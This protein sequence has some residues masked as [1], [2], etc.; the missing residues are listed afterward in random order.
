VKLGLRARVALTFGVLSLAV[1]IAVSGTTY[2]LARV[3]L[4]NQRETAALTRALLDARA[5]SASLDAG[6]PP[7]RVL[8]QIPSVGTSQPLLL[9]DG[10]WYTTGVTVSPES[11]PS[12]LIEVTSATGGAWQRFAVGSGPYLAVAVGLP[13]GLYVEVFPL[14][15]LDTTFVIAGWVV[16]VLA[17]G[18]FGVGATVGRGA[19]ARILRPLREL[20][21]G[22]RQVAAGDYSVRLQVTG[23][24]D[25]E[26]IS[27]SFNEMAE[28]VQSQISRERRF[29]ANVS[30]EL[31]SPLTS[32]LGTAELLERR[33]EAL[34][35]RDAHIV[36]V[37]VRQ[38]RR[39]SQMVLDL[40]E[41]SS[42]TADA[43][44][45]GET[46]DVTALVREVLRDRDLS[47]DL[48]HGPEALAHTDAR[49]FERIIGNLV[50]NAQ[51][52]GGGVT[53]IEVS[54][55]SEEGPVLITVDDEGPG[56]EPE[57][58]SRLFEPFTRGSGSAGTD[59]AGLGL[60]LVREQSRRLG[61]AVEI[62]A[63]PIGRGARFI[64]RLPREAPGVGVAP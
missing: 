64:V 36:E 55:T 31:R 15:D 2:V 63:N 57:E 29:T 56:I 34:P 46:A 44:L 26:P 33:R 54:S 4:L 32:V 6:V 50:D 60:A 20:S 3:Y 35:E 53:R 19:G 1:A 45:L 42:V 11:L 21:D 41:I 17:V 49:R 37:L 16:F 43:E 25:L 40:L 9:V 39:M 14:R 8:E 52:H 61:A 38:V 18:S 10:E 28:A 48:V 22:A 12:D 62:G 30:H 59:G 24:P 27:D 7:G 23:D 5:A 47:E 58:A 13:G 51:R